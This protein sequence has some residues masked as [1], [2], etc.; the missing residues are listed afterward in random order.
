MDDNNKK[1][2]EIPL[3]QGDANAISRLDYSVDSHDASNF[4]NTNN[5][6]NVSNSHNTTTNNY[7][8]QSEGQRLADAKTDYLEFC[9]KKIKDG[10]ISASVRRE[11]DDYGIRLSLS[12]SDMYAIEQNVKSACSS[13]DIL[14]PVDQITLDL[15]R[16][17]V[18]NNASDTKD[19]LPKLEALSQKVEQDEV[20]YWYYLFLA[21][22]DP[23]LCIKRYTNRECD[24]Y[25]QSYWSF[26]ACLRT[27]LASKANLIL[28]ELEKWE[29]YSFDNIKL[30]QCADFLYLFF[31][32]N[33]S[34]E[35]KELAFGILKDCYNISHLLVEFR[36]SL[37]SLV[38]CSNKNVLLNNSS[39]CSFYL[40]LF[41]VK[42]ANFG[43]NNHTKSYSA[44][45]TFHSHS[46]NVGE[47]T[48][49]DNALNQ[50]DEIHEILHPTQ[51]K[52]NYRDQN[53]GSGKD[54]EE[55]KKGSKKRYIL[56]LIIAVA[57]FAVWQNRTSDKSDDS[58]Q[59]A[60]VA[61]EESLKEKRQDSQATTEVKK[62]QESKS[63]S[64]TTVKTA[65][66]KTD[67]NNSSEVVT[68]ATTE[69]NTK[70]VTIK[71]EPVKQVEVE[72]SS[73]DYV[74]KGIAANRSFNDAKALDYF[75]KAVK[76]GSI[77]ANH[78]IGNLYY[79]GGN[80]IDK[81]YPV[82]FNYYMKAAQSGLVESQYMVGLMYRNGQGV[83]KD[84]SI[85]KQW[86]RKASAK[87][88][89][90]AEKLLNSL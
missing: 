13:K 30:L 28:A 51:R 72:L 66:P 57:V 74:K 39:Q 44:M 53:N 80:S 65:K 9:K 88:H 5:S 90:K 59:N 61:V 15:V 40:R 29:E 69:Q 60:N 2:A 42:S 83:S 81:S 84:L 32:R 46:L 63:K 41:E 45:G 55:V 87:G 85:A 89:Q 31:N 78:H 82:A 4:N 73:A 79:N 19:L 6:N 8:Q 7:I 1:N 21:A 64:V 36:N 24:N 16:K 67:S 23:E 49:S 33:G 38:R 58:I 56:W 22:E 68:K 20:Q 75:L 77:E 52:D 37:E 70:P 25:W 17:K 48:I 27:G 35:N 34:S 43:C 47:K 11:L 50:I 18:E 71:M 3:I 14:S 10:L 62:K 54:I 26:V 12:K 86:L 76:K